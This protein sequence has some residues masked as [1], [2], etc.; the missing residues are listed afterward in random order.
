MLFPRTYVLGYSQPSLRDSTGLFRSLTE[1]CP[2]KK[3]TDVERLAGICHTS[4]WVPLQDC[5]TRNF[6]FLGEFLCRGPTSVAP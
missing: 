4:L 5:R 2:D 6:R 1:L 3:Q